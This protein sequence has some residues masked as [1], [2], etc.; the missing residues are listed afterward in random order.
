MVHIGLS[1]EEITHIS[2]LIAKLDAQPLSDNADRR[3]H[4]RIDFSH[5][6][7]LNLPTEP[8]AP[9]VHIY[10]RNLSTGGLS[11]LSRKLF[12]VN[13]QL[14][15]SHELMENTPLLVLATV[16]F[17]R[18]VEMN[19]QEVGLVFTAIEYDP[20]RTRHVPARWMSMVLQ[21]DWL[22]RRKSALP[23]GAN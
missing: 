9:W 10:S 19:V 11:F 22:A 17:C 5:P 7:W 14:V 3:I 18:N 6:M 8:G 16:C 2:A 4:P 20:D 15:I 13:Q 21:S 1:R 12:Y 23:I